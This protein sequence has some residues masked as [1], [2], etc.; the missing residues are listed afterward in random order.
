MLFA[1]VIAET[2]IAPSTA[3]LFEISTS[4]FGITTL[5][6]PLASNSRSE[7]DSVVVMIFHSI[8]IFSN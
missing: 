7:L 4:L 8:R 5:P 3:R 1:F 2:E 6:V